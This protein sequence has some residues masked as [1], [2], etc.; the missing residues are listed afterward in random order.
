MSKKDLEDFAR[1]KHKGLPQK[2][3]EDDMKKIEENILRLV[4]NHIPPHATKRELINY[5]SKKR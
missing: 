1:T 4:Q 5:I 3:E 2:V